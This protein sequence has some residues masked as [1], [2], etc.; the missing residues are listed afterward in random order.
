LEEKA[1]PLKAFTYEN[2]YGDI[3]VSGISNIIL[4]KHI[5]YPRMG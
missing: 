1:V 3:L 5:S 4:L 2:T